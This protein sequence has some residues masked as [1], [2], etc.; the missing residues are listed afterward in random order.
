MFGKRALVILPCLSWLMAEKCED[1]I[2]NAH[3]CFNGQIKIMVVG[4]YSLMIYG[5]CLSSP[6]QDQELDWYPW[7][8]LSL[9]KYISHH[10]NL[11][12]DFLSPE[13]PDPPPPCL[14][15]AHTL[16]V[17]INKDNICIP[18]HVHYRHRGR[19]REIL[20]KNA[21]NLLYKAGI[22]LKLD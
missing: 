9:K 18:T 14:R 13:W 19:L 10:N 6:M 17:S 11:A 15:I 21:R 12:L 2:S 22:R 7:L 8:I 16:P 1:P 3:G 4:S 20:T 5:F